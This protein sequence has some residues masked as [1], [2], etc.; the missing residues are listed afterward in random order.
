VTALDQRDTWECSNAYR[1]QNEIKSGEEKF[2][3]Y[4][5][6][7]HKLKRLHSMK[8]DILEITK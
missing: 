3:E 7:V 6:G 5:S 2:T 1:R 8:A 4:N